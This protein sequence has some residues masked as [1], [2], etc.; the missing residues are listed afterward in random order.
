MNTFEIAQKV[1]ATV[2][3]QGMSKGEVFTVVSW[4]ANH[5]GLGGFVTYTVKNETKEL[6]ITNAQFVLKAI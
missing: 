4:V 1:Q 3:A 2:T 6:R 5:I